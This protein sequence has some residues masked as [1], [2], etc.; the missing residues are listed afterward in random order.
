MKE[1]NWGAFSGR[2]HAKKADVVGKSFQSLT[3][4]TC[5]GIWNAA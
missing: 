3:I 1:W 5:L 2:G 4:Q